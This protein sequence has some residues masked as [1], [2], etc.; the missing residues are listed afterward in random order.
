MPSTRYRWGTWIR[1]GLRLLTVVS[2]FLAGLTGLFG[3]VFW[4]GLAVTGTLL[5]AYYAWAFWNYGIWATR[6]EILDDVEAN[7]R[8]RWSSQRLGEDII[9]PSEPRIHDG[10]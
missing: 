8:T 9:G 10:R 3:G 4:Y 7:S 6:D 5:G 2:I 1:V